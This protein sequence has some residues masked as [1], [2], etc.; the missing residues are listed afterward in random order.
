M[1]R[2]SRERCERARAERPAARLE[3]LVESASAPPVLA[4]GRFDVIAEIKA[5]SPSEGALTD[6]TVVDRPSLAADYAAGGAA[7]VSVLTEPTRFDGDLPHLAAV[8]ARLGTDGPPAMRKDFLVD[9]YQVLEARLAGA[10]GVLLIAA[11]LDDG[12]LAGMLDAALDLGLFVLLECFDRADVKRTD[13]L[14]TRPRYGAAAAAGTLLIGV[15]T[16]DLRTLAVDPERL[17]ALA[18][19]LPADARRVAESGLSDPADAARAAELGYSVALIGT[20]LMRADDPRTRLADFIASG[21][22]AC[23]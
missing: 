13:A 12:D 9:P 14:L 23:A 1:A 5:S 10:G 6:G 18:P 15:N 8:A 4:L 21:R 19:H 17:A 20:A 11:M 22:S 3:S 16:R 2:G 7:A